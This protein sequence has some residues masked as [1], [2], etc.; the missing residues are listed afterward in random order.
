MEEKREASPTEGTHDKTDGQL[1][2]ER[3]GNEIMQEKQDVVQAEDVEDLQKA[4]EELW[5][6]QEEANRVIRKLDWRIM[7]LIFVLYSL[8]ILDRLVKQE[9][10][11]VRR[12]DCSCRSNLGNAKL[13]GLVEDVNLT[14]N[15]YN[16]LATVFYIAYILSQFLMTGWKVFPAYIWASLSVFL[17]GL[18][19]TLQATVTGWGSLMVC[20]VFLGIVEAMYGPGVPLYLSFFYSREKLGF[21][22][23]KLSSSVLPRLLT[24]TVLTSSVSRY[25]PCW[26]RSCKCIWR[27]SSLWHLTSQKLGRRTMANPLH[28]RRHTNMSTGY[29]SV[30]LVPSI[31]SRYLVPYAVP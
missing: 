13:A 27:R 24:A 15:K 11:C 8:S 29:P 16:W 22:V 12:I 14:G 31:S 30:L 23:G 7:P 1:P 18:V 10:V 4:D 2:S 9:P 20:R 5:Y 3:N 25:L 19:S 21:R 26:V 28:R 6:T 17:W